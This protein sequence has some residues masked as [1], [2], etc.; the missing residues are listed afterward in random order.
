MSP[1]TQLA[2]NTISAIA[3]AIK[4]VRRFL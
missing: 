3:P 2:A 1:T 4:P